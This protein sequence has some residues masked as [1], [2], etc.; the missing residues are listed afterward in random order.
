MYPGSRL[1]WDPRAHLGLLYG[2]HIRKPFFPG[3]IARVYL[4][5]LLPYL[6]LSLGNYS[7]YRQCYFL[8]YDFKLRIEVILRLNHI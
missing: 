2:D 4:D 6:Q 1:K 3:Q 7:K 5:Y 8:L